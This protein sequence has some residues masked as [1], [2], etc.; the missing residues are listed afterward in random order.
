MIKTISDYYDI[1]YQLYPRTSKADIRKILRYGWSKLGLLLSQGASF[2]INS[3]GFWLYAGAITYRD[4]AL[5]RVETYK[6]QLI[7]KYRYFYKR[8]GAPWDGY[9]YYALTKEQYKD[10]CDQ[11]H[12][13]GRRKSKFTFTNITLYKIYEECKI[14]NLGKVHFFRIKIYGDIGFRRFKKELKVN[15]PEL[16]EILED[17]NYRTI[18]PH[19]R[20]FYLPNSI[21]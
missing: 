12:T 18:D 16:Y 20:K 2:N 9:Y 5:S 14:R 21:K 4:T 17:N 3:K 10:Y 19:Y 6:R 13:G 1:M 7:R 11:Q 15:K 8:D